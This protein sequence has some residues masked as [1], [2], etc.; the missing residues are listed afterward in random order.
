[1]KCSIQ[2]CPGHY[3]YR[4]IVHTVQQGS[5]ILVFERVPA[6]I[7]TICGDILLSPETIKTLE[8]MVS[9]KPKIGKTIPVYEY[10]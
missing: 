9:H 3:E 6:E 2:G 5:D 8:R 10:A 7:C 1:M 4:H